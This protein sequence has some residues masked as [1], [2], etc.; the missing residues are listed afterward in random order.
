MMSDG[1]ARVTVNNLTWRPFARVQP[2]LQDVSFVIEPGEHV[3]LVG[4][5]GSGKSSLL[6]AVA[7]VLHAADEG[8]QGGS[9][10]VESARG[11]AQGTTQTTAQTGL[12]LQD[13]ANAGVAHL[14][15]RDVA[16]GL[17]NQGVPRGEIW[18][19]VR[20]ALTAVTF[21]FGTEHPV[22][23]V[24]GGEGQRLALAGV[25]VMSPHLILLDEPT[26]MLDAVS[27][28]A[29]R[30]AVRDAAAASGA[31]LIVVE[32]RFGPWLPLVDRLLVLG[33]DGHLVTSGP[34]EKVLT[35]HENILLRD[36][37]WIPGYVAPL[38]LTLSSEICSPVIS[39]SPREPLVRAEAVTSTSRQGGGSAV[40][41]DVT[42]DIRAGELTAIVGPSGAG[43][44]TLAMLLAGLRAPTSGRVILAGSE[45]GA[46]V[47]AHQSELIS[48]RPRE[49]ARHMGWVPQ[50]A[51]TTV[52][53][54]SVVADALR[55]SR[56]LGLDLTAATAR[57]EALLAAVNLSPLQGSDPHLLSGGEMRRL[58]LVGAIAHGP[59]VLV[60]DEPTVGQDRHTWAAVAGLIVAA[61][62]A[63]MAVVVTT[64]D[65]DLIALADHVISLQNE[66]VSRTSSLAPIAAKE[67][68]S[69][70]RRTPL[71][72]QA[73][74]LSLVLAS[75][76]LFLG[77]LSMRSLPAA[78]VGIGAVLAFS[79]L[80]IGWRLRSPARLIPGLIAATSIGFST[81]LLSEG[82]DPRVAAAAGLKIAYFVVPTV[83]L[84]SMID[85]SALGDH[86]AQRLR[87]PARPVLAA[88][89]AL[90]QFQSLTDQWMLLRGTRRVRGIGGGRSPLARGREFSALT[91][92]FL[93]HTLRRAG[94]MSVAMES[95]GFSTAAENGGKRTWAEGAPWT[96]SDTV[97]LG[98]AAL[99]A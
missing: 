78:L 77:A 25:L 85:P 71:A 74:P 4:A 98:I 92:E 89:A 45:G 80:V 56:E 91:F 39:S 66:S 19:R 24:S 12:L 38:P 29:V 82:H 94:A 11:S 68:P 55:T 13:P 32:H 16:F 2:V 36:G 7:G 43:K 3:L 63:G 53:G 20:D 47:G 23:H 59:S 67:G 9:V 97:L 83:V 99:V 76:V 42:L 15:G 64:H 73:G 1:G 79:P 49:L 72:F 61:R 27:A 14:V 86:L 95:R 10:V 54:R 81:W 69:R 65:D 44:S 17:E 96:A 88:V 50:Q 90:Q 75:F 21:P 8:V 46:H 84:A 40:F 87:F 41:T 70:P 52:V 58:A 57:V 6:R 93:V 33:S 18:D 31:T 5:S 60:L 34:V 37:V 62:S 26:S 30:D 51:E 22:A 28:D 48:L 35:T